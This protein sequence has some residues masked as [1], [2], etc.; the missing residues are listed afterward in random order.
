MDFIVLPPCIH[1][2]APT[3][4]HSLIAQRAKKPRPSGRAFD[5]FQSLKNDGLFF[6]WLSN[7]R[8]SFRLWP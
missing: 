8:V 4:L 2:I 7:S 5:S 3:L 1:P 6:V